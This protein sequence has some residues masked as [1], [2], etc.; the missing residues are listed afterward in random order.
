MLELGPLGS[1][2]PAFPLAAGALASLRRNG[3]SRDFTNAWAGQAARLA[4]R[5]LGSE[6]LTR[7]LAGIG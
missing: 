6:E 7:W 2:V 4:P 5:G 3:D 1:G